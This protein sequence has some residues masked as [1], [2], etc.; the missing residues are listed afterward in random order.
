MGGCVLISANFVGIAVV[1]YV[2]RLSTSGTVKEVHKIDGIRRMISLLLAATPKIWSRRAIGFL[3]AWFQVCR[4][5]RLISLRVAPISRMN[6]TPTQ[7][8]SI[9]LA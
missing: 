1:C 2:V 8:Y 3:Q 7:Q 6:V 9:A 4:R 5:S